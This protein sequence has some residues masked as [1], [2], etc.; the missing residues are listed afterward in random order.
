[1]HLSTSL[2]NDCSD[3]PWDSLP[4]NFTKFTKAVSL[5]SRGEGGEREGWS[6]GKMRE[7]GMIVIGEMDE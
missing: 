3:A 2:D 7:D 1:M 4:S 5:L 6:D